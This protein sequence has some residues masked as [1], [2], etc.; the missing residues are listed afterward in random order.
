ML[1]S[2]TIKGNMLHPVG[3]FAGMFGKETTK[4]SIMILDS[5]ND[6][7]MPYYEKQ[8]A[9]ITWTNCHYVSELAPTYTPLKVSFS[10]VTRIFAKGDILQHFVKLNHV[11]I[12]SNLLLSMPILWAQFGLP[13]YTNIIP[14]LAHWHHHNGNRW[15]HGISLQ[16]ILLAK[17]MLFTDLHIRTSL[18]YAW[19]KG[20]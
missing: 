20:V 9:H 15:N 1:L 18:K 5:Y 2:G 8:E 14:A 4:L 7:F 11:S 13:K 19:L 3:K 6:I 10:S 17:N 16:A 12:A